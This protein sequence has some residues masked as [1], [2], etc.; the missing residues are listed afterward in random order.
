MLGEGAPPFHH[1]NFRMGR[2]TLENRFT[3]F[4]RYD[5]QSPPGL[6]ADEG[7][8]DDKDSSH[9]AFVITPAGPALF[10]INVGAGGGP[11]MPDNL[12]TILALIQQHAAEYPGE[13]EHVAVVTDLLGDLDGNYVVDNADA[14]ILA[15]NLNTSSGATYLM[16]DLN[17]DGAIIADDE[18]IMATQIGK[19]LNPVDFDLNQLV[20]V[21]DF[22]AIA[23][24]WDTPLG[25]AFRPGDAT[26][27]GL[28]NSDDVLKFD[29]IRGS[30]FMGPPAVQITG[31]ANNDGAVTT[32]DF[33]LW[34]ANKNRTDVMPFTDGD[35]TG[36]GA[37]NHDDLVLLRESHGKILADVDGNTRVNPV[38]IS[39][40]TDPA[41]WL[42]ATSAGASDGDVNLDGMVD[43]ADLAAVGSYLGFS[44]RIP[45]PTRNIGILPGDY[46]GDLDIDAADLMVWQRTLGSTEILAADGNNNGMVDADDL[47]I[48][49]DNFEAIPPTPPTAA[50]PEPAA[51]VMFV[52]CGLACA[53]RRR[54]AGANYGRTPHLAPPRRVTSARRRDD[55]DER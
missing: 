26:G 34:A 4:T 43:A 25:D 24:N 47:T 22:A 3:A 27:D 30:I 9:P 5:T 7:R 50:I 44:Y 42:Q 13:T 15:S 46:D 8:L 28:V 52:V 29:A 17:R 41:H 37:V 38:D 2:N 39:V 45:N 10:N 40:L 33:S 31:D 55:A 51:A 16:G 11:T 23:Q 48:W 53:C 54:L 49:R 19:R 18:A 32:A 21:D 36:D 20:D 12:D 1:T 6:G 35:V 14:A